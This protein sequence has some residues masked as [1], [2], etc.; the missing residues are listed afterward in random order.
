M[1]FKNVFAFIIVS[2]FVV[3]A[4][5]AAQH[6]FAV[7]KEAVPNNAS[8]TTAAYWKAP[9]EDKAYPKWSNMSKP[10]IYVSIKQQ[11][12]LFTVTVKFNIS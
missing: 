10:W 12:S 2:V 11:K 1:K 4:L 3:M 7:R 6:S 8:S 9:S 5:A